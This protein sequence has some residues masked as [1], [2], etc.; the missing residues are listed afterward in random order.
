LD[1]TFSMD[2]KTT[3]LKLEDAKYFFNN[4]V[5]FNV[6]TINSIFYNNAGIVYNKDLFV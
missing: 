2:R 3:T 1:G 5:D 6:T 4:C